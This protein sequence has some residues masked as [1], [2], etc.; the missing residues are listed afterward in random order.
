ME[1]QPKYHIPKSMVSVVFASIIIVSFFVSL[2]ASIA[3]TTFA[4]E[5]IFGVANIQ[6]TEIKQ[7]LARTLAMLIIALP[8]FVVS[9]KYFLKR[10]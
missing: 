6:N 4:L 3:L 1:K 10:Y 5:A 2:F 8:I 9:L 7:E